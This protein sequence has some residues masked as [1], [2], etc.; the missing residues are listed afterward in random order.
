VKRL[1]GFLVFVAI[2]GGGIYVTALDGSLW[3][4]VQD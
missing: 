4:L 3:H 1:T 2:L